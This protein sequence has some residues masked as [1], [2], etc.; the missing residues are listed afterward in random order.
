MKQDSCFSNT[1]LWYPYS[2][3][4]VT[5]GYQGAAEDQGDLANNFANRPDY[6][7]PGRLNLGS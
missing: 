3:P 2:G 4:R 1:E 7:R 5:N 6:P